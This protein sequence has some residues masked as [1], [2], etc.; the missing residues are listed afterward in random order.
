L[1]ALAAAVCLT[2]APGVGAAQ[3]AT[4]GGE[5]SGSATTDSESEPAAPSPTDE[6]AEPRRPEGQGAPGGPGI[7]YFVERVEIRGNTRT[8]AHVIRHFV[9]LD[10]GDVLDVDDP[11]I[12]SIR[13]RLLGTGW[14]DEV[15]LSLKRGSR[16]GWVVLVVQVEE[17]NTFIINRITLGISEGLNRNV[18]ENL[19]PYGGISVAE[20][21]LLGLGITLSA[22][23]VAS[24]PQQGFR[25]DFSDPTA[26]G[27]PFAL[28][29]SV[30]FNNAREFFGND[31]L[32]SI[33][34]PEDEDDCPPEVEAKNAVVLYRRTGLSLGTGHDLGASTR[35]TLD[36]RVERVNV[37][38][39]P[40]AASETRGGEVR[41]IDFSIEDGVSYVSSLRFGLLYD[42][43]NDP[44]LPTEGLFV[45]FLG[46]GGTR[47]LGSD[48]DY[49]R[50]QGLARYWIPLPRRQYVRLGAFAG[51]ALGDAPFFY[52]F[53]VSDMTD[54]IPSRALE[55]EL[56]RRPPPNLLNT[57]IAVMRA[58]EL[59]GRVDVEYGV[60]LYRGGKGF[61]RAVTAYGGIGLYS[62]ADLRDI[63]V[64][65][66][67]YKGAARVPVDLTFDL[68]I[69]ADTQLGV[70]QL[71]FSNLLGFVAL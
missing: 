43:R 4:D 28:N 45:R 31:P 9:P 12:E 70:F 3:P 67:G 15:R 26:F 21:N 33:E 52:K 11:E 38:V 40:E 63:E 58:E 66:R 1:L 60:H 47:I 13:W 30:F 57:S 62:L 16:R 61:F 71:G 65:I 59:A 35:Y 10:K 34:C 32:V 56:D 50:L 24:E 2:M 51:V 48:Y 42:R 53:H 5:G 55:M 44:A 41:P 64:S 39:R 7:R 27:S 20:T 14:F 49:L 54:L 22:T 19:V 17:R 68:G 23:V 25:L 29:T 8:R 6:E 36:W 37:R 46:D 18:D 69:R